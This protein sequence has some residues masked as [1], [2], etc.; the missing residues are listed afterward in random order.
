MNTLSVKYKSLFYSLSIHLLLALFVVFL[1][2]NHEKPH[3][4]HSLVK[5]SAIHFSS[6][7]MQVAPRA[8]PIP[9]KPKKIEKTAPKT[10]VKKSKVL[11]KIAKVKPISVPVKKVKV[12]K[13]KPIAKQE[14][15]KVEPIAKTVPVKQA[16]P[17][18]EQVVVETKQADIE[19]KPSQVLV[20]KKPALSYEAQ[21]MEDNIALINALIKKNLSYPRLAKKRG[22]QGKTM[23]SFTLNLEGEVIDIEALGLIASILKK[24]AI[25]TV[26]KAAL[27]FP[28]PK[29]ALALRIPIVY[30]LN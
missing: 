16:E 27:S 29:Q 30:K 17:V 18:E 19:E 10:S 23:V 5:L 21:Y 26:Q 24:S 9:P 28:H 12:A 22:L 4:V 20:T 1:Y 7:A 14:V 13:V 2:K 11:K 3:E 8:K 15:R 6:P 25:K